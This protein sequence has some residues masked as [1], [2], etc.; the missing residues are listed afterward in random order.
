[1]TWFLDFLKASNTWT[2]FVRS[3]P[4]THFSPNAP[5]KAAVLASIVNSILTGQRRYGEDGITTWID[6]QMDRTFA[7]PAQIGMGA[8][9]RRHHQ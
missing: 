4:L 8:R 7:S 3:C 6:W 2:E 5:D 9:P 1:L